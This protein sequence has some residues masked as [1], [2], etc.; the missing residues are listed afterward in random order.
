MK[1]I[2]TII[3]ILICIA[4]GAARW[5]DVVNFT[6]FTT[7]F[8]TYGSYVWRYAIVGAITLVL[9]LTS[10]A[11]PKN[12]HA[13]EGQSK[14]QGVL[15]TICGV[16]FAAMGGLGL[17]S[18]QTQNKLEILLSV[19]YLFTGLWMLL[20]GK[21]RFTEEFEA[22]SR[23]AMLGVLG[24]LA[25]YLMVIERFG[26]SPTGIVRVGATLE[27]LAALTVL[28]FSTAQLKVA[29]VPGG[30]RGRWVWFSG[31]AAFLFATCLAL[32]GVICSYMVGQA[33]LTQLLEAIALAVMGATGA[34][35]AITVMES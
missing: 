7:G 8:V 1:R 16:L 2:V 11:A 6:D 5:L 13:L 15:A 19:L 9:L 12:P 25:F 24:T 4:A 35:Y 34:T 26:L 33:E 10:F 30:K 31:M 14:A 23:S 17:Y 21:T 29:Y 20:L 28:L 22:P 27:G 32:P 3:L 18:F